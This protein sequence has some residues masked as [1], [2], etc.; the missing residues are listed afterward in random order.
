[1]KQRSTRLI[2]K[3]SKHQAYN[4]SYHHSHQYGNDWGGR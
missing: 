1:M 2:K 4:E 3:H